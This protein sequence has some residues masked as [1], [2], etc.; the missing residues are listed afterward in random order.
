MAVRICRKAT[1][2]ILIMV[3]VVA[4][5]MALHVAVHI[6]GTVAKE[7]HIP[8]GQAGRRVKGRCQYAVH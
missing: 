6:S 4:G 3:H 2:D 5:N 8:Q 7:M 1:G